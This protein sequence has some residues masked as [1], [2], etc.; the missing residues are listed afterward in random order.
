M[1][2]EIFKGK[3]DPL[4]TTTSESL[5]NMNGKV[6][7]GTKWNNVTSTRRGAKLTAGRDDENGRIYN[8]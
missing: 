7:E 3:I 1:A 8:K 6:Y 4:F 5:N 2:P